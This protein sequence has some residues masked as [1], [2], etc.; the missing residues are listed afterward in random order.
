MKLSSPVFKDGEKIPKDY[1]RDGADKS[2]PL[3]FEQI[4]EKARSLALIMD[5]PDATKGT[6]NHWLLFNVDPKVHDIR[7]GSAPVMATQGVNDWGEVDYGGPKPPSGEHRYFFKAFALDTVLPLSRG[8]K[9]EDI[10]KAMTGH[11]VEEAT[12]MGRYA[13][14]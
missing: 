8:A 7:E 13:R 1:T 4:P 2:P 5:D 10:E 14:A 11:I 9:R 3:H 12:L 6:F